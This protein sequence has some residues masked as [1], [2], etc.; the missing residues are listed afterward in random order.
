[1]EVQI[2]RKP[3]LK[4]ITI[5]VSALGQIAIS[6]PRSVSIRELDRAL[7]RRR[8]WIDRKLDAQKRYNHLIDPTLRVLFRGYIYT[9][10]WHIDVGDPI[11]ITDNEKRTIH[12]ASENGLPNVLYLTRYLRNEAREIK[13]N[14]F[15]YAEE[16]GVSINRVTIR[17]QAT[18]WGSSSSIGTISLNW[19]LVMAPEEVMQYLIIHELA[20]QRYMNHSRAFWNQVQSWCPEYR[21]RDAWLK[22]HSFLLALLR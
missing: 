17:N 16:Y 5:R 8:G 13:P 15:R 20:H 12:V 1:M 18:R 19:C 21:E 2:R 3:R 14:V 4:R 11:R 6:A 22:E 10:E 7:E 9:V